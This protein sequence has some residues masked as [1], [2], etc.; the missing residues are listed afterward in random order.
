MGNTWNYNSQ[1][2]LRM[3]DLNLIR[4][5]LFSILQKKSI[6]LLV[7]SLIVGKRCIWHYTEPHI[8]WEKVHWKTSFG[9]LGRKQVKSMFF[10]N[11]INLCQFSCPV[12]VIYV[13]HARY[14][15]LSHQYFE[16]N[17]KYGH[18]ASGTSL[19]ALQWYRFSLVSDSGF[20]R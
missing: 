6:F 8:A 20:T 15:I 16:T 3:L 17:L 9:Y 2:T 18:Q 7:Y 11:N 5:R 13:S 1:Q 19:T 12:I 4:S 14:C 10:S